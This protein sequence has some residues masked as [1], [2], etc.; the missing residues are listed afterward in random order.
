MHDTS[1][2]AGSFFGKLYGISGM[3]VLDVGGQN[4]NGSLMSGLPWQWLKT[5]QTSTQRIQREHK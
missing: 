2:V 1:L 3:K 4:F 5:R